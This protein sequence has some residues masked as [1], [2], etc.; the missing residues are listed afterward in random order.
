GKTHL[1]TCGKDGKQNERIL[2]AKDPVLANIVEWV[3][4]VEG[5]GTYRFTDEQRIG[6][7]AILEAVA[8]SV[9][10]GNWENV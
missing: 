5:R 7:V 9:E 8:K 2:D 6:N 1:I 3:D 4:A 10:S